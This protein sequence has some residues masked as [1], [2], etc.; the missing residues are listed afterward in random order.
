MTTYPIPEG[1]SLDDSRRIIP[2]ER[3]GL[4][5]SLGRNT[6]S[7]KL[8]TSDMGYQSEGIS[9]LDV[10]VR[11]EDSE[12]VGFGRVLSVGESGELC[13]LVVDPSHRSNGIGK[14]IIDERLRR[15][16]AAGITS[17]YIPYLMPTNT[18]RSYYEEKGF[19]HSPIGELVRGPHPVSVSGIIN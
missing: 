8:I 12:L 6:S 1:Y 5:R 7:P 14:A 19:R 18:L 13:S 15:A 4:I 9:I 2:A 11:A 10:G 16:E 3:A 17:F